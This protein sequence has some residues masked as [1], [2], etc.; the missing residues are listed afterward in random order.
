MSSGNWNNKSWA[1]GINQANNQIDAFT[2]GYNKW[3]DIG[4]TLTNDKWYHLVSV[5][6]GSV[7]YV[8]L[9]GNLLGSVSQSPVSQSDATNLCIGR[10]TYASGHFSFNGDICDVRVYDHALSEA[11]IHELKSGLIL[12]YNFEDYTG[13]SNLI[14][15]P[16]DW[17]STY[18]CDASGASTKGTF[19]AQSDGSVLVVD[20]N[21]NTRFQCRQN[22]AVTAGDILTVS[23]KYK[24]VSGDQTFRWQFTELNSSNGV[25]TSYWSTTTQKE[26]DIGDGWKIIY[27]TITIKNANTTKIRFWLQDGADYT[28]YTHSYYIKDFKVEKGE[29]DNPIFETTSYS[30]EYDCSGNEHHAVVNGVQNKIDAAT[31]VHSAYFLDGG[32]WLEHTGAA[33]D[34]ST[35][36]VSL[37]WKS[38][39]AAAKTSYHIPLAIDSGR[40]EISI[41]NNGQL[42]WGGYI[43]G[44]RKCGNATCV[45]ANGGTFSLNNGKWHHIVSV[46]DGTGFLGYV[47]GVYQG[48]QSGSGTISY[49]GKTL[50]IGKY[51]SPASSDYG[52]T[53]AYISDVRVYNTVLN[54]DDIARLYKHTVKIT[55]AQ[56]VIGN[57][58]IEKGD[59]ENVTYF[60]ASDFTQGGWSGN[61]VIDG[62]EVILTA[63]NGWRGFVLN[64]PSR[65]IGKDG[66]LSFEYCFTDKTNWDPGSGAWIHTTP[67]TAQYLIGSGPK[68][69]D[70]PVGEWRSISL[71]LTNLTDYFGWTLRG[72]QNGDGASIVMRLRNARL[73]VDTEVIQILPTGTVNCNGINQI[74][75]VRIEQHGLLTASEII[76]M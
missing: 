53:D 27:Q 8:Y 59:Q 24:N 54:T 34:A 6:K 75:N 41:P 45:D 14:T 32:Q 69:Y 16:N 30:T 4:Y 43:N 39:C 13:Q 73:L 40:V 74:K 70:I 36:S 7:N 47:D 35:L 42:R 72:F 12:H 71:P 61:V 1:V 25:T 28:L 52:A 63:T 60:A 51:S 38:S 10:E 50:R 55:E 64:T 31:G 15:N 9:D 68:L 66:V 3:V 57:Y 11:E 49:S 46:F 76:E 17:A 2:N 58:F 33:F 20:N 18:S 5:Q 26:I 21:S 22:P 56:A 48:K 67:K 37:W 29:T 65:F 62:N 23:I 19:T 44:S